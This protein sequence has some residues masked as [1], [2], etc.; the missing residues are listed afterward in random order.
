MS[1]EKFR[2][3]IISFTISL[4]LLI[5]LIFIF[6]LGEMKYE[7]EVHIK[8]NEVGNFSIT[9]PYPVKAPERTNDNGIY[10]KEYVD[11]IHGKMM[12]ITGVLRFDRKI[13]IYGSAYMIP[14]D[15]DGYTSCRIPGIH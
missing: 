1:I 13:R 12:K 14:G 11:T 5:T 15:V 8:P 2:L 3:T 4:L 9:I 7:Y 10:Q 6:S